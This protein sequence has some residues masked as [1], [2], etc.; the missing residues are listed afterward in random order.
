MAHAATEEERQ[1]RRRAVVA[2]YRLKNPE[3]TV[4]R[5]RDAAKAFYEA[6]K[7]KVLAKLAAKRALDREAYNAKRKAWAAA[8]RNKVKEAEARWRLNHPEEYLLCKRRAESKRRAAKA[9][10]QIS[11]VPKDRLAS[12]MAAAKV[13]A[14]CGRRFDKRRPKQ[15][16]HVLALAAGGRHHISNFRIICGPCNLA[17]NASPFAS[18]GQGLLI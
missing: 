16:D 6:N 4:A 13:C 17:K 10:A 9:G 12:M 1:E 18:N 15:I 14:D 3:K 5:E 7:A 2:L 8:N 11:D